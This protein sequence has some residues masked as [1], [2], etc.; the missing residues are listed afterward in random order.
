MPA[1]PRSLRLTDSYRDRLV[2]T[3]SALQ[4]RAEQLWPTIETFDNTQWVEKMAAALTQAQVEAVRLSSAY[5]GAFLTTETGRRTEPPAL[6]SRAYAGKSFDGRPL[7][8]SLRSPLVGVLAA[9]KE[10]LGASD[11]LAN[12][13]VRA[14]RMVGVDYDHAH[15]TALLEAIA[16]D[17][18]FDGWNRSLAGT[19]GACAAV[20]A[21]LNHGIEF[22]VHPGC[23]CVSQPTVRM[24]NPVEVLKD[25]FDENMGLLD[26]PGDGFTFDEVRAVNS[27]TSSIESFLINQRL[28]AGDVLPGRMAQISEGMDAAIARA[29]EIGHPV[30]VFRGV[31]GDAEELFGKPGSIVTDGGFTSTTGERKWVDDFLG[32]RPDF[33]GSGDPVVM[34][35]DVSPRVRGIWGANPKESELLLERG[36]RYVIESVERVNGKW[37]VKASVLPPK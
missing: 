1:N 11:S 26:D 4:T 9:L 5:L 25:Q 14:T 17:P 32:Q 7:T 13:L 36:C 2:A 19:C 18:R 16:E 8:E 30:R 34:T 33:L 23:K 27:Y 12:G 3:R 15:R 28:R 37:Q 10:G 6:D 20:A 29:G 22:Q 24:R 35:L 21:G 31:V